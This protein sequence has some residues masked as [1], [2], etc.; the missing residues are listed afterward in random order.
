M[1][2]MLLLFNDK[3]PMKYIEEKVFIFIIFKG[4]SFLRNAFLGSSKTKIF[5]LI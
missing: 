2:L 3:Y 5:V 1:Y 4:K